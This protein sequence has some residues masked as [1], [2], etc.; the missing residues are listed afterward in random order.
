M[1][2]VDYMTYI[3]D[4]VFD[5]MTYIQ[6]KHARDRSVTLV[7]YARCVICYR[8]VKGKALQGHCVARRLTLGEKGLKLAS[9]CGTRNVR[10]F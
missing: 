3:T 7:Y 4:Q 9:H 8:S 6:T 2:R 5:H 10:T 1:S